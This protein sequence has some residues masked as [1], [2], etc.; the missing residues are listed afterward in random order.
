M[1]RERGRSALLTQT[2]AACVE[3][4]RDQ[5]FLSTIADAILVLDYTSTEDDL[6][7]SIRVL[8]MRGSG[9][10]TRRRSLAIT[11]GGLSV[12][13]ATAPAVTGPEKP[14]E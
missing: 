11:A 2:I 7:R 13:S 14:A 8:K 10:D 4:P 5:P 12:A 9:H 1:L 3:T 6:T